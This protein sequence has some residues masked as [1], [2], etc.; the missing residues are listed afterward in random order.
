MWRSRWVGWVEGWWDL[1][2]GVGRKIGD[3]DG[4]WKMDTNGI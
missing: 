1:G 2:V 4:E 3:G